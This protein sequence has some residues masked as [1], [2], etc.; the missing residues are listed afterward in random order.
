HN[1]T[2]ATI[3]DDEMEA[4]HDF[5]A[6]RGIQLVSDE[7]YHPIYH[8]RQTKSAARLPHATVI[9]DMSKAFS[10]AGVRTG[11]MIEHDAKR[12]QQYWTARAYFSISNTT[13]GEI[14]SEI[15]IRK[16]DVVL[17]KTRD[18]ASRNLKLLE[19]FMAD[20]RDVLGWIPPLG[21]MTAFP[22]LVSGANAPPFCPAGTRQ[23]LGCVLAFPPGLCS[24]RR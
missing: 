16:R 24:R 9:A 10:I 18:V 13:T 3:G 17:G 23:L 21:G 22:W 19:R 7:V 8:G 14:L 6:E 20:H 11:W 12:R 2:G 4:L 1:P 15:T 5:T